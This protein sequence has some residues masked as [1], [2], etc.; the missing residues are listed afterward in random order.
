MVFGDDILVRQGYSTIIGVRKEERL[1]YDSFNIPAVFLQDV[2]GLLVGRQ[3]EHSRLLFGLSA[4][5][6]R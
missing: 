6:R 4:F 1:L 3:V 2:P 5:M